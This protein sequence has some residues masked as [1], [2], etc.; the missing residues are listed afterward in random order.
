MI[1]YSAEHSVVT[2]QDL[3]N[4]LECTYTEFR[5]DAS[6]SILDDVLEE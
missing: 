2:P 5:R 6:G 4:L 3:G 1:S